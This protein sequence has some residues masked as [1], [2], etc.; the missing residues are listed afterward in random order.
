MT[1]LLLRGGQHAPNEPGQRQQRACRGARHFRLCRRRLIDVGGC[2]PHQASPAIGQ[3]DGNELGAA[4][5]GQRQQRQS[6]AMQRVTRVNNPDTRDQPVGYRGRVKC[7]ASRS[8]QRRCLTAYS[9]TQSSCRSRVQA[10]GYANTPNS[11]PSTSARKRSSPRRHPR[12]CRGGVVGHPKMATS[13]LGS[14]R[15]NWGILLRRICGQFE[16]R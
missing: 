15:R 8:S 7:S 2:T 16:R 12:Q 13:N 4:R 6:L 14:D 3:A 1:R 9:T 11:C 5:T 10:T